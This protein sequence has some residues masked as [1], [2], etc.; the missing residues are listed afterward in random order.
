MTITRTILDVVSGP[1][2]VPR[3]AVEH[4]RLVD[5]PRGDER[6]SRDQPA[7]VVEAHLAEGLSLANGELHALGRDDALDQGSADDHGARIERGATSAT[8]PWSYAVS[9]RAYSRPAEITGTTR[10]RDRPQ[11]ISSARSPF[12]VERSGLPRIVA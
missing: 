8:E 5:R 9:A 3:G 6:R 2:D 4:A 12:R 11:V 10:K 7:P 1:P